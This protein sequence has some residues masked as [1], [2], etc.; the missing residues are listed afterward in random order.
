MKKS[1]LI[2]FLLL[3]QQII[4]GQSS[5]N[6]PQMNPESVKALCQRHFPIRSHLWNFDSAPTWIPTEQQWSMEIYIFKTTNR[7][8]CRH[9]NGCTIVK[10]VQIQIDD[11]RKKIID[12]THSKLKFFNYE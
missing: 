6:E 2:L 7:G 11:K 1:T 10:G 9:T 3:S 5:A 4:L 8:E 12:I